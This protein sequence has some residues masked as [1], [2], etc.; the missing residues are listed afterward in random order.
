MKS[1]V[2]FKN[3]YRIES[4]RLPGW[5]YSRE[6]VYFVTI[7]THNREK[8]FGEIVNNEIELSEI[9]KIAERQWRQIPEHFSYVKLD[10]F[11]IMPNHMHGIVVIGH[12]NDAIGCDDVAGCRD[13]INRVSTTAG[14]PGGITGKNNPMLTDNLSR[15]I[16]WFKGRV[17]FDSRNTGSFFKW[18]A[19]FYDHIIRDDYSYY[20]IR[21]YIQNNPANWRN[22]EYF[23][24]L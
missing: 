21:E 18:Q 20:N 5:D 6:G 24:T 4:A 7:C 1:K 8:Y 11:V 9:G 17:T 16:R 19:R 10:R 22:D 2:K 12:D 3:K 15:V 13:A 14:T 23:D